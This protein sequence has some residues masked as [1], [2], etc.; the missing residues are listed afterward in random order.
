ML[1]DLQR[2]EKLYI[3]FYGI[4]RVKIFST[5]HLY[6]FYFEKQVVKRP[7]LI[8]HCSETTKVDQFP[9]TTNSN[10]TY[11]NLWAWKYLQHSKCVAPNFLNALKSNFSIVKTLKRRL[12]CAGI[13]SILQSRHM[14]KTSD[15][16]VNSF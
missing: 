13:Y 9:H 12:P 3:G 10:G 1:L 8:F 6:Y 5:S 14:K 11:S 16:K 15:F 7:N 4:Y 2:Y